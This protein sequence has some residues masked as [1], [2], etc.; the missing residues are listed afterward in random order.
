MQYHGKNLGDRKA[1]FKNLISLI[2]PWFFPN[3]YSLNLK[4]EGNIFNNDI[5]KKKIEHAFVFPKNGLFSTLGKVFQDL[6]KKK[7]IS[8][9]KNHSFEFKKKN[10]EI[11]IYKNGEQ[12]KI[13]K[14]HL[15]ILCTP[16]IPLSFS[17]K[18]YLKNLKLKPIK[19]YSGLI[20]IKLK[21]SKKKLILD[22]FMEIIVSSEHAKGLKRIANFSAINSLHEKVYQ[23][24]FVEHSSY[25]DL[26]H[27]IKTIENFIVKILEKKIDCKIFSKIIDVK[28]IRNS[29]SPKKSHIEHLRKNVELFF[30]NSRHIKLFRSITWPINTN[31]QFLYAQE[32]FYKII[33][34]I[35]KS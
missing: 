31:K 33:H 10:K 8:F 3:N 16:I 23:F 13:Q 29:F 24:E 26:D 5:R 1:S 7:S 25:S 14:D 11:L 21:N 2:Y 9:L 4:D 22:S 20:K 15:Y 27:Q 30:K 18:E 32:D 34:L 28:F 19:M 17:I 6:L 12:K 35:K